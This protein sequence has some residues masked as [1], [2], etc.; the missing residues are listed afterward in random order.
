[1]SVRR[2]K[3]WQACG[4]MSARRWSSLQWGNSFALEVGASSD[5]FSLAVY[6]ETLE[7]GRSPIQGDI[8]QP[9]SSANM[10]GVKAGVVF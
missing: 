4:L 7:F 9:K 8:F 6:A 2:L 5:R 10:I 1:M 3:R